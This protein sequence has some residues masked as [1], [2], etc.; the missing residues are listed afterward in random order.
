MTVHA[1]DL[2]SL[3]L[4]LYAALRPGDEETLLALLHPAF[5]AHFA[6]GMPAGAGRADGAQAARD[7][8]WAIG[9]AYAARPIVEEIVPCVD[10]RLLVRGHYRG[11]RRSDGRALDAAFTHLWTASDGRLS[12]LHQLTD[13]ALW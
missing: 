4:G 6:E 13:T 3:V 2:D 1:R 5:V 7:H 10:G 9:A 8:W 11:K 12:E